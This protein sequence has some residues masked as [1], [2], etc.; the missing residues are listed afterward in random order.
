M[1]SASLSETL[2]LA[3]D[4][5]TA[6][7][8]SCKATPKVV[9]RKQ[10]LSAQR[11]A[12]ASKNRDSEPRILAHNPACFRRHAGAAGGVSVEGFGLLNVIGSVASLASMTSLLP[13]LSGVLVV[14]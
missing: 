11:C 2:L 13:R 4:L 3:A 1:P 14:A 10:L 8:T 7:V 6:F 9:D 5:G 12:Q